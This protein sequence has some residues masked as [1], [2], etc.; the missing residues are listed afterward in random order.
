MEKEASPKEFRDAG[1][2]IEK[3]YIKTAELDEMMASDNPLVVIDLRESLNES[4]RRIEGSINIT[5]QDLV[6]EIVE[7]AIPDKTMPIVL[8]CFQSFQ[9]TRMVAL[10]TFA[11]PALKLIGYECVKVLS[12]RDWG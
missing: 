12:D 6:A 5:M 9:M 7:K 4:D 8:V 10:T 3:N 11:Y 1:R 2:D